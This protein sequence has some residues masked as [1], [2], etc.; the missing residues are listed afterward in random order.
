MI[1]YIILH[2]RKVQI[3]SFDVSLLLHQIQSPRLQCD[4]LGLRTTTI[5]D[6]I[7]VSYVITHNICW[8]YQYYRF[9]K[10]MLYI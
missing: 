7:S 8:L 3:D 5:G 10:N 4:I 2:M 6:C 1:D 9:S